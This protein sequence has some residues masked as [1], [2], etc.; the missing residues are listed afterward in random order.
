MDRHALRRR[1]HEQLFLRQRP[2]RA[3][4]GEQVGFV[5]EM[6]V[7]RTA[8]RTSRTRNAFERGAGNALFGEDYLGRIEDRIAG[9][10]GIFL[11]PSHVAIHLQSTIDKVIQ[12]F[13]NVCKWP[14]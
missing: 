1:E 11:G 9:F 3:Q 13:T 6:P 12:T 5:L 2:A 4:G 10:F 7:K 14:F 8:G